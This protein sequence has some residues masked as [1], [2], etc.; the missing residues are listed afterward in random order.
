METTDLDGDGVDDI[1]DL[2]QPSPLM[3]F[4]DIA[5]DVD[6]D[7]N[8]DELQR[9]MLPIVDTGGD[10]DNDINCNCDELHV[11]TPISTSDDTEYDPLEEDDELIFV[12][13]HL[14]EHQQPVLVLYPGRSGA[15]DDVLIYGAKVV[16]VKLGQADIYIA[17]HLQRIPH[18]MSYLKSCEQYENFKD[19]GSCLTIEKED[20]YESRH[21]C[22]YRRHNNSDIYGMASLAI[23]GDPENPATKMNWYRH[24]EYAKQDTT[25]DSCR[26]SDDVTFTRHHIGIGNYSQTK[27]EEGNYKMTQATD[28]KH[29]MG[30]SEFTK[31][32][33]KQVSDGMQRV[34]DTRFLARQWPVPY[35]NHDRYNKYGGP[36]RNMMGLEIAR[37]ELITHFILSSTKNF[38]QLTPVKTHVDTGNGGKHAPGYEY[39]LC[40]HFQM[41]NKKYRKDL[42]APIYRQVVN[43]NSRARIDTEMNN[44]EEWNDVWNNIDR[45]MERVTNSYCIYKSLISTKNCAHPCL[46][47]KFER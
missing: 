37:G 14:L 38:A 7:V 17:Q 40:M 24:L 41:Q 29:Y 1:C 20:D 35:G 25:K 32:F 4:V 34:I 5:D 39:T 6:N 15:P 45:Y 47:L 33:L 13:D 18:K 10:V 21:F 16:V 26:D 12:S 9:H 28:K 42:N 8:C 23:D 11:A 44:D 31:F 30:S 43:M 22:I 46:N 36:F 2:D 3:P 27:N 19:Y